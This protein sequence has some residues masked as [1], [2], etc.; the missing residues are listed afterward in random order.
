MAH[1]YGGL[2]DLFLLL[3]CCNLLA[4][5]TQP[6]PQQRVYVLPTAASAGDGGE[7]PLIACATMDR[8]GPATTRGGRVGTSV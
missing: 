8:D 6:P 5:A 7:L 3:L 1:A 2:A 4:R